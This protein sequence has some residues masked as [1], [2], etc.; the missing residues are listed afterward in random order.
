[1]KI[2][3]RFTDYGLIGGFFWMVQ[4][5]IWYAFYP[6]TSWNDVAHGLNSWLSSIPAAAIS[7]CVALIGALALIAV[8]TTGVLIDLIGSSYFRSVEVRVFIGHLRRNQR[9]LANIV[10]QNESYIQED[11][12][13]LIEAR[14]LWSKATLFTSLKVFAF[15]NRKYRQNYLDEVRASWGLMKPYTRLQSFLLSYVLLTPGI[16]KPDLLSAQ[17]SLWTMSRAIATAMAL[18]A[19][20][21]TVKL[22][23]NFE[24]VPSHLLFF[25]FAQIGLTAVSY[26]IDHSAHGRI[27]TTLFSLVYLIA[28][29]S[30]ATTVENGNVGPPSPTTGKAT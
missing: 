29:K 15:W 10:S 13:R 4:A 23:S 12:A 30:S 14:P 27:C 8:F 22:S 6:S 1:M 5:F 24:N 11:W 2:S 20:F 7:A 18:G 3:D 26:A 21:M 19:L 28:A 25:Y 17:L 9:W 16:A